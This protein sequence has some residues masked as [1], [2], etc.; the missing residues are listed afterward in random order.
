VTRTNQLNPKPTDRMAARDAVADDDP[1][2]LNEACDIIFHGAITEAS[3]RAE[4]RRGNLDTFKIGRTIFTTR[5]DIKEMEKKC[6]V[7]RKGRVFTSTKDA[8][9]GLSET[10]KSSAALVALN[11]T[12]KGLK[13]GLPNT[14]ARSTGQRRIPRQ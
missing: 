1:I 6:R 8:N 2:T 3:L 13:N 12:V 5:R 4:E 14:L 10:D 9:N 7:A 11:Q